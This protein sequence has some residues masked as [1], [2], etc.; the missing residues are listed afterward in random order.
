VD[1]LLFAIGAFGWTLPWETVWQIFLVNLLVKY[2][3]TML[4]LPL[5]YI[6]PDTAN[7]NPGGTQ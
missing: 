7:P 2:G 4:S 3:V 5:I 6:V 1:N